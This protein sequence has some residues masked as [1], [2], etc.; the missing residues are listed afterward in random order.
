MK[1]RF[2]ALMVAVCMLTLVIAPVGG[3]WATEEIAEPASAETPAPA[4]E[5]EPKA[6][7]AAQSEPEPEPKEQPAE[8]PTENPTEQ[9]TEQPVEVPT[10]NPTEQPTEEPVEVP[11]ESPSEEPTEQPAEEPTEEPTEQPTEE[12]TEAPTE[13]PTEAPVSDLALKVSAGALYAFANEDSVTVTAQIGGSFAPFTVALRVENGGSTVY[14]TA[15]QADAAGSVS[16]SYAPVRGGDHTFKITV[17]DAT[18]AQQTASVTVPVAVREVET[19]SQWEKTV[20]DVVLT[21]NWRENLLAIAKTQLGYRE[22]DV[23]FI[24]DKD[25]VR[26]FYTR[27]GDWYGSSYAEWC[28]MFVSFCLNYAEIPERYFPREANC[29]NWKA[30]LQGYGAYVDDE[31]AY[32]PIPG[33]LIFFNWEDENKPQHVGIVESVSDNTVHTIEGNSAASVRRRQYSLS[34]NEIVGYGS[35]AKLMAR[36]GL[37]ENGQPLP[38]ESTPVE[39]PE[40]V[41]AAVTRVEGVNVRT[42]PTTASDC[43]VQLPEA[44]TQVEILSAESVDGQVWYLAQIGED[45]GYIRGDLLEL[46][47]LQQE[48]LVPVQPEAT[49][50]PESGLIAE[51]LVPVMNVVAQPVSASWQP[52]V[53]EIE[54]TFAVDEA[55]SYV[56]QRSAATESG[57]TVWTD[58]PGA[59]EST[60]RL[61]ADMDS[62]KRAYRCVAYDAAGNAVV[63]DTVTMLDPSLVE[64]MNETEVTEDM[65]ARAVKAGDLSL[66][67]LEDGRLVYVRTGKAIARYEN[68]CII[69]DETGLIVAYV[70]ETGAIVPVVP[71]DAV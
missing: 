40:N 59:T 34:S 9:P 20:K 39:L 12:P 16:L 67:V 60:V 27:Y 13:Q 53:E 6:E 38:V 70:D 15:A 66:A 62:L 4:Q 8:V 29:A 68:G 36:A 18:G 61:A 46:I 51:E 45:A 23:N 54:F 44:G 17:T 69:D 58:I 50:T 56:W 37:D 65:L 55:V 52:G 28:A 57:E 26:H 33:D 1:R 24:V 35:I 5:P 2:L 42:E 19:S 10:E 47:E 14:E 7:P 31:A 3:T 22:S 43:V 41:A 11:T 21:E 30:A 49:Q 63:S 48:A 64:W 71:D 32:T 25:G